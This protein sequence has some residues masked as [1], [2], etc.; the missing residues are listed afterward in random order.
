M[1]T[2]GVILARAGSKGLPG[3]NALS[4]AGRPMIAWTID[5]ARAARSLDELVVS[6]DGEAIAD[7][8]RLMNVRVVGRPGDLASDTAT[9][10]AAARHA[11]EAVEADRWE[12]FDAVV[13]L[14][15]NV[16]VRP[17]G[18]VDAAVAKLRE[19]GC[20]SVQSLSEVGK[21]H[22]F[23]MKRLSGQG[24]DAIEPYVAN[25]VYRRQ[26]LEKL[27]MLDG[28][29]IAVQ[30]AALFSVQ[31]EEPHAFLGHDQRAVITQPGDVVDVD[32][33]ADLAVAEGMLTTRATSAAADGD[34][35]QGVYVVAE[36]GVNHDG[37]LERALELTGHAG[38]AGADAIKVQV[39]NAV[40]LLSEQAELAGYQTAAADDARAM[41]ERLQLDEDQ[42][43]QVRAAAR[44][45]GLGFVATCFSLGDVAV[46]KRLNV[47]AV[48]VASPDAVNLPLL[49]ALAA[50]GKPML[51]ST[52]ACTEAELQQLR[53][54]TGRCRQRCTL[55][56]CISAYPTQ[57]ADAQLRWIARMN[58]SG[59]G[60]GGAGYSD[61]TSEMETGMLAVACGATV[62]EKHL[63]Y[64]R[65]AVGPDHAASFDVEQFTRYVAL[66]RKAERML[67]RGGERRLLPVEHD[68]RRVA[69]QSVCTTRPLRKGDIIERGD[70]TIKRPGTGIPARQFEQVIGQQLSRDVPANTLLRKADLHDPHA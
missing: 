25:R 22:P 62:V 48:K 43:M 21:M 11:V 35:Q 18:L 28:G 16:P 14:Y 40:D 49:E 54:W 44:R 51:I 7:V 47:D 38:A 39:F 59:G 27:Y 6:T 26:D 37:S 29:L 36:L 15:A 30:R 9:V 33:A 65:S 66:I 50:L 5:H 64:D 45:L 41:L 42:L 19:T 1:R 56:H 57:Q 70:L 46:L 52:G 34:R 31:P 3:K 12:R 61:H 68:V 13:I 24:G 20:D 10:D 32:T 8:A 4:V 67:G 17:A 53:T 2:L 69:R 60:G 23:W 63:T 58:N 55:M